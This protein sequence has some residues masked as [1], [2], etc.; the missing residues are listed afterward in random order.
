VN[1]KARFIGHLD[2]M[3]LFRRAVRRAGGQLA[4]TAG[5]RPKPLLSLALPLAVG[6]EASAELCEFELAAEPPRDFAARLAAALPPGLQLLSLEPYEVVKHA[7]ARVVAVEYE[8]ELE[9]APGVDIGPA[10]DLAAA[11]FAAAPQLLREE[12]REDRVRTLDVKAYVDHVDPVS[13]GPLA[14]TVSFRIAVTPTGSA[15]PER[16]MEALA[17]LA[18]IEFHMRRGTRTKVVLA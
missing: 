1:G 17:E 13:S 4:R 16:V 2:K 14:A 15:R 18:G 9:V 11:R 7:A 6:M 8:V 5:L 10:L 3:E 12:R